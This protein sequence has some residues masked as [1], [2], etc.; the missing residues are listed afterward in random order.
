MYGEGQPPL[1]FV[2]VTGAKEEVKDID[3]YG[4]DRNGQFFQTPT[5]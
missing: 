2:I 3:E 1:A 5:L 4:G